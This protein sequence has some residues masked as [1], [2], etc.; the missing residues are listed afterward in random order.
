MMFEQDWSTGKVTGLIAGVAAIA[1]VPGLFWLSAEAQTTYPDVPADYW[2][3]PF[4]QQLSQD[5]ILTGY[6][7]GTFRPEQPTDRDEYAAVIRQ[8]FDT[9]LVR[10]L[11]QASTFDDVPEDYWANAA[12]SEAYEM[13]FMG[14]PEPNEFE[15][16]TEITRANAIVALVEG[17]GLNE[18]D[19]PVVTVPAAAATVQPVRQNALVASCFPWPQQR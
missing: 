14:T 5:D 9:E 10:S 12:I 6:P 16:R 17:L 13:G 1:A 3:Q 7:D 4:I 2:A 8:A 11:P 19:A 18:A 15:P